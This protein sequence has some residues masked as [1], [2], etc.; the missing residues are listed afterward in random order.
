M[1]E[2][3]ASPSL[4]PP[5]GSA[6]GAEFDLHESWRVIRADLPMILA[7]AAVALVLGLVH[8]YR[9]PDQYAA[10]TKILLEERSK[11]VF[12]YEEFGIASTSGDVYNQSQVE[13]ILS[14]TFLEPIAARLNLKEHYRTGENGN[15]EMILASNTNVR[16]IPKTRVIRVTVTDQDPVLSAELANAIADSYVAETRTSKSLATNQLISLFG[17]KENDAASSAPDDLIKND[18]LMSLPSLASDKLL[19]SMRQEL[20]TVQAEISQLSKR[21][22]E[23][24]PELIAL[25]DREA[26]I[27][28]MMKDQAEKILTGL[29]SGLSEEQK[30]E[31]AKVIERASVPSRPSGPKR[32]LITFAWMAC[33]LM[34]SGLG[35]L[36]KFNVRNVLLG[37]EDARRIGLVYLGHLSTHKDLDNRQKINVAGTYQSNHRIH[38]EISALHISVNFSLPKGRNKLILLTSCQPSEGKS[39]ISV[40]LATAFARSGLKTLLVDADMRRPAI[41]KMFDVD[42]SKGL[43]SCLIGESRLADALRPDPNIPNLTLLPSGPIPP[44]PFVLLN[45]QAA[46]ELLAEMGRQYDRVIIDA[47]PAI[48]ISDAITLSGKCDGTLIVSKSGKTPSRTVAELKQ[49]IEFVGGMV[50]GVILNHVTEKHLSYQYYYYRQYEKYYQKSSN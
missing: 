22:T 40:L 3:P 42:S 2:N 24:H 36:F 33:G 25:R 26:H 18:T 41:S 8:S 7:V 48:S 16:L 10:S 12:N 39:T 4:Q 31:T 49:R 21:Y 46:S 20:R 43:S 29:K 27:Q 50:C 15:P 30:I 32:L 6:A 28:K 13:I 19:M 11:S 34:L 14:R 44:N 37:A 5:P 35:V 9:M 23:R 38:D 45:S 1:P 17:K 47:P